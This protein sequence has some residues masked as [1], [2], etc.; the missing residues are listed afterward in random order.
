MVLWAQK[1]RG[2]IKFTLTIELSWCDKITVE[3]VVYVLNR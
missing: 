2:S 1:W 3:G